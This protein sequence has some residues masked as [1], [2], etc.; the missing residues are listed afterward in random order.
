MGFKIEMLY[1]LCGT[2]FKMTSGLGSV[3]LDF[4]ALQSAL[5]IDG[6]S[7]FFCHFLL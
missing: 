6:L 2:T 1:E 5:L 4:V 7:S 3:H